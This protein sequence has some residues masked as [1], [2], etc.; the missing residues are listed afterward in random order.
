[1]TKSYPYT[2]DNGHGEQFTFIGVTHGPDGDRTE[3]EGAARPGAGPPMHV[4]YL[5]EEG[6]RVVA[7]R[8][9][10]QVPG[11]EPKFADVGEL[12]VWPAGT[13]HK[14]WNA[15]TTELR[16][17]GWC[18]PS[19]NIEFF[20]GELFASAKRN[21]GGRPALFDTA[22]LVTHYRSEYGMLELPPF[23]QHVMMPILF[24]AGR[25]LGKHKKYRDAPEP[26]R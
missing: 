17:R 11:E 19:G 9:G 18:K 14:W 26:A 25:V 3:I 12:V 2:I 15:G 13:P 20:L 6:V 16:M 21:G 23:V 10:Y 1:V 5:Q 4:H 7:G 24:V 8:A 22:F